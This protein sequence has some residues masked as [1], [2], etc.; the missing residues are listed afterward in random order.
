MPA[1]SVAGAASEVAAHGPSAVAADRKHPQQPHP[2]D[3]E[4]RCRLAPAGQACIQPRVDDFRFRLQSLA[5]MAGGRNRDAPVLDR[6]D[7]RRVRQGVA[8]GGVEENLAEET[9]ARTANWEY[10]MASQASNIPV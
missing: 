2:A 8:R 10:P 3:Q 5:A 7:R 1:A 4:L 6:V 9:F